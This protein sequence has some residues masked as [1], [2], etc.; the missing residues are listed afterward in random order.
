MYAHITNSATRWIEIRHVSLQC[1]NGQDCRLQFGMMAP[2]FTP[3]TNAQTIISRGISTV[4]LYPNFLTQVSYTPTD[5][6]ITE[7]TTTTN[8]PKTD[9]TNTGGVANEDTA[10]SLQELNTL[11]YIRETEIF[12]NVHNLVSLY[13]IH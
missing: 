12:S 3:L 11:E 1:Q 9:S 7:S 5:A 6:T 8:S 4:S 10:M 2:T 13:N